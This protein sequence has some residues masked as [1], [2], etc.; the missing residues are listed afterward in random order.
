MKS[1]STIVLSLIMIGFSIIAMPT[2]AN[3]VPYGQPEESPYGQPEESPYGQPEESPYGQPEESESFLDI[4]NA[5]IGLHD[6][7]I[8]KIFFETS[9]EIPEDGSEGAFGYGV[10]TLVDGTLNVIATTTHEGLFD[11][12]VQAQEGDIYSPVFHNHF[13]ELTN[14]ALCNDTG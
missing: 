12:V 13:V 4:K 3:A 10:V 8:K 9:G 14:N 6:D 7:I 1:S 2:Y 5:K 11:S